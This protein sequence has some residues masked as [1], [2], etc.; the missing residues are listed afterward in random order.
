[1]AVFERSYSFSTNKVVFNAEH[2]IRIRAVLLTT[3]VLPYEGT[4]DLYVIDPDGFIVRKWNSKELNVGVL[5][6]TFQ[7]PLYPKVGFW[8][9]RV[10]AEGQIEELPIKVE[11]HYLPEN[12]EL[13][14]AMR[15]F[16]WSSEEFIE[17]VVEGAFIT[18]RI[19]RGRTTIKW[20]AKK[21]DYQTPMFNDSVVYREVSKL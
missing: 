8:K 16:F 9:I 3:E 2:P 20:R 14:V 6:Q 5:T 10:I 11:K 12:F 1:M 13:V 15:S 18:E 17:A 19:A 7:L 21:I 4:A